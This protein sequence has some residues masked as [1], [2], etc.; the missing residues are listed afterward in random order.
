[1]NRRGR[2]AAVHVIK[3][4]VKEAYGKSYVSPLAKIEKAL[5]RKLIDSDEFRKKMKELND[6]Y[7]EIKKNDRK[8]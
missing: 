2:T 4:T 5:G 7:E 6:R 8:D 1:M 3:G